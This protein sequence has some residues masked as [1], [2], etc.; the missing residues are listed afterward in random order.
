M[1]VHWRVACSSVA[2]CL[3]QVWPDDNIMSHSATADNRPAWRRELPQLSGASLTLREP[4]ASDVV[5]V[6][7][8]LSIADAARFGLNEPMSDVSAMQFIERAIADRRDGFAFSYLVTL[9]GGRQVVG[10]MQVRA[11]DPVFEAAE[12]EATLLTSF[13]GTGLFL[14]AAGLAGSFAFGAVGVHRLECRVPLKNGRANAA[15]RKLGA[16]QEGV[17][18]RS[19]RRDGEYLDQVLWSILREDWADQWIP[20]GPRVH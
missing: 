12:W 19:L 14:E 11:L 15:L 6:L 4:V 18:R 16:T 1:R 17:L 7:D 13:R 20:S 5:R 10:A 9:A 2:S 3:G 8:L